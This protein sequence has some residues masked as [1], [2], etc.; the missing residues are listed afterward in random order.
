MNARR[1]ERIAAADGSATFTLRSRETLSRREFLAGSL[2]VGAA[3]VISGELAAATDGKKTFTILHTNDMHSAFIGM[4]PASDY[5]PFTLN[6]DKTTGGY[7]RI[8][9]VIA[10]RK[11][12]R[13]CKTAPQLDENQIERTAFGA[14]LV[15]ISNERQR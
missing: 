13:A 9:T 15:L 6:D 2:V 4:G 12:A 1:E 8:A 10:T 5:T 14:I 3:I 11:K 7:A